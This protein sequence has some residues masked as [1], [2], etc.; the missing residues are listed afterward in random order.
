MRSGI[1]SISAQPVVSITARRGLTFM[2]FA[3]QD[4]A[5]RPM[6]QTYPSLLQ[7]LLNSATCID[8]D[9]FRE[10]FLAKSLRISRRTRPRRVGD[11][12]SAAVPIRLLFLVDNRANRDERYDKNHETRA[13]N[14]VGQRSCRSW[15]GRRFLGAS[16]CA[17]AGCASSNSAPAGSGSSGSFSAAHPDFRPTNAARSR[18]HTGSRL[19]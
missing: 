4:R 9:C 13:G 17:A 3:F 2:R 16:E 11:G 12:R 1:I 7:V 19:W 8:L 14:I 6:D 15:R 5:G 18:G 10:F